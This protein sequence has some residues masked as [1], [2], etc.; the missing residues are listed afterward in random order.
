MKR[1]VMRFL[2]IR[3]SIAC[4]L[5]FL[6][7]P[8]RE[9]L[10][11]EVKIGIYQNPPKVFVRNDGTPAGFIV[12]IMNEIAEAEGWDPEYV[13][14]TWEENMLRLSHGDLDVLLDVTHTAGRSRLFDFNS[15]PVIESWLQVFTNK[16]KKI[17]SMKDLDGLR[18]AVLRGSHQ[19]DYFGSGAA[20]R[21]G[22]ECIPV[23]YPDY[24][25]TVDALRSG[26]ADVIV[27]DRFF[28]FSGQRGDD[29]MPTPIII[30]PLNIL[31]AFPKGG[32]RDLV[33]AV[34]R[35][36]SSMKND[37]E[38][39]Y[40]RI[41]QK[42]LAMK[43]PRVIPRFIFIVI[44]FIAATAL[45]LG[46]AASFL[47]MRVAKKT[48]ELLLRNAELE[49]TR[50]RLESAL[51][52]AENAGNDLR[53]V[54]KQK[55]ILLSELFH[56]TKNNMQM[57]TSLLNL[58][59]EGSG[60]T[61]LRG[62][63]LDAVNRIRA[64]SMVHERLDQMKDLSR[65]DLGGYFHDL[66]VHLRSSLGFT[67][68]EAVFEFDMEP[69]TVLIDY[70]IPCGL[71][72]NELLTNSFKH[73]FPGKA[74]GGIISLSLGVQDN[75]VLRIVYRDNGIGFSDAGMVEATDSIGIKIVRGI[76]EHQLNGSVLFSGDNGFTCTISFTMSGYRERV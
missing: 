6:M 4:S 22:I 75:S 60:D 73:A 62:G 8:C 70:A 39:A 9:A 65:I 54:L 64:M 45:L 56:R 52:D 46:I 42:N 35:R 20:K 28:Y 51:D 10:G 49:E 53:L 34:D 11:R 32:N 30:D 43:I 19:D 66:A 21:Y 29:I 57:I 76:T 59:A 50:V 37:P 72:I 1:A 12:E 27:A 3:I 67:D 26:S 23:D 68:A 55:E 47:R 71:I 17:E 44:G 74:S 63:L 36:L 58:Q 61:V 15:V 2:S 41:L 48:R 25:G 69:V 40:Y 5:L 24:Q 18:I 16:E 13:F 7:L 31:F 14:G 38:S 33:A